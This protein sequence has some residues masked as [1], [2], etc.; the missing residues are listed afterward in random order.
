M[1]SGDHEI[2]IVQKQE[3]TQTHVEI[4]QNTQVLYTI[5]S[6]LELAFLETD[7]EMHLDSE[8]SD[9]FSMISSPY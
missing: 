5:V 7:D 6:E 9:I 8:L 2:Q 3:E 1:A 4:A